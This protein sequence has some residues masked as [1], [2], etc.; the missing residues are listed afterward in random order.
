MKVV[1]AYL[2]QGLCKSEL[3]KRHVNSDPLGVR[4]LASS[5]KRVGHDVEV[6]LQGNRTLDGLLQDITSS[7]PADV[8]GISC[9]T[10]NT[11]ISQIFAG[12]LKA[13]NPRSVIIFG[14]EHPSLSPETTFT[15][16]VDFVV[17]GEGEITF[18]ELLESIDTGNSPDTVK[19][20]YYIKHGKVTFTGPRTPASIDSLPW[21]L[22]DSTIVT[23]TRMNS[24]FYPSP[25][26]QTGLAT[27]LASRGCSFACTYCSSHK[28]WGNTTRFRSIADINDEIDYILRTYGVNVIVFYDLTFN[29]NI[30]FVNELCDSFIKRRW[31]EKASFYSTCR[32]SSPQGKRILTREVLERMKKA[33]FAKIGVGIE[34]TDDNIASR[35]KSG[36]SPWENNVEAIDDAHDLGI[37]VRIFL[38]IGGPY[39]TYKT[40]EETKGKLD[41]LPAHDMR[42]SFITPFPGTR[43]DAKVPLEKRFTSDLSEYDC[44]KPI[45]RN[46]NFTYEQLVAMEIDLL[47]S[48]HRSTYRKGVIQ[49]IV[50]K[51]PKFERPAKWRERDL[52][53]KG[54]L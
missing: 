20:I 50:R 6:Y 33:G 46:P 13:Y 23:S 25:E 30:D 51:E 49:E 8:I 45:I 7:H 16:H 27:M 48:F 31:G 4:Y 39:E 24:F 26:E 9:L 52:M 37:L 19:G 54:I 17:K 12:K 38:M 11:P 18:N 15:S 41:E 2:D 10:Y 47:R 21:P 35:Y 1:L 3:T 32:I 42:V 22:R 34:S 40:Y 14:G 53:K 43:L 44:A 28:V 29:A 36:S 5:L